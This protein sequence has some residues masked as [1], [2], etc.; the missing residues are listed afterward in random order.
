MPN[1][2]DDARTAALVR[3][4]LA[5]RYRCECGGRW[6]AIAIGAPAPEVDRCFAATG[7]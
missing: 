2:V 3:D 5:A 7:R 6:R 1:A 4:Y